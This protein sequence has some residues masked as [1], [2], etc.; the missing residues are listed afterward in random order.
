M[1][2]APKLFKFAEVEARYKSIEPGSTYIK[3]LV[4]STISDTMC[5][6]IN[7]LRSIKVPWDL[8][9]DEI[10]FCLEGTFR[11]VCN[12]QKYVCER[13]DILFIPKGN[14]ISYESDAKCVIFYAAYP[15]NWKLLSGVTEVPGIDP[16]DFVA[17]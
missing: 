16:S 12:G 6:G 1:D 13:G 7:V 9:C 4:T 5:G 2:N 17:G 3:P 8:T 14:H 11:L 10:I 15:H